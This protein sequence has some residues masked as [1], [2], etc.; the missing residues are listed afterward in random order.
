MV[1]KRWGQPAGLG[2]VIGAASRSGVTRAEGREN[3]RLRLDGGG[4]DADR[5]Q[6]V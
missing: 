6:S 4:T 5:V 2:Q 3:S 1:P